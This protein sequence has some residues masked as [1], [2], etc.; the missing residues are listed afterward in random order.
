METIKGYIQY[1]LHDSPGFRICVVR[2]ETPSAELSS[3]KAVGP[4]PVADMDELVEFT[5]EFETNAKY[6]DQFKVVSATP[7]IPTTLAGKK[8]FL[9]NHVDGVGPATADKLLEHFGHDIIDVLDNNPARLKEVVGEKTAEKMIAS[10]Q[11]EHNPYLRQLKLFLAQYGISDGI[12]NRIYDCFGERSIEVIQGNPY[13]LTRVSGIGFKMADNLARALGWPPQCKERVEAAFKYV[14]QESTTAG[15]VF[16]YHGELVDEVR[17]IA[18]INEK[19]TE[20]MLPKEDA[21]EAL[22][23]VVA[24][25]DLSKEP[26]TVNHTPFVLYYL[27]SLYEAEKRVA[28]RLGEFAQLPHY[29]PRGVEETLKRVQKDMHQSLTPLQQQAVISGLSFNVSIITGG[30]GTGKTTTLLSL[31][32]TAKRLKLAVLLAAPTGRA[33]KRMSEVT[34][35]PAQT[36]HRLLEWSPQLADFTRNRDY[37]L[38][39][40]LLL[41]D[42]TSMKDLELMDKLLDA[43]PDHMSVVFIGDVDQLPSVGPGMV[44]R[45]LIKSNRIV[46]T[47]L[48]TIF[49]QAEGS[50]IVQNAHRIRKGENP[51]F[52]GKGVEADSYFIP[53]PQTKND[54]GKSVDSVQYVKEMLPRLVDRVVKK[55]KVDPIRDIQ[56]LT[57]MRKG[58]AGFPEFNIVLQDALNPKGQEMTI[59]GQ[60]F[61]VGDR[62]MQLKNEYDQLNLSNGD[63][64]FI[65]SFDTTSDSKKDHA[66]LIDFYGKTVRYP[67]SLTD[68]LVLAYAQTIH[69]S[70]G[71]EFPAVILVLLNHHYTMLERN[72]LYTAA[73]R[74]KRMCVYLASEEALRTA[75]STNNISKRNTFLSTR[76]RKAIP[77]PIVQPK[78][79]AGQQAAV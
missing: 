58:P 20:K 60:K 46:V 38:E 21:E 70:Q 34:G 64:G 26:V 27:P 30:P 56:V 31:L 42:E 32:H 45:D 3:F 75:V 8:K 77:N 12:S 68:D 62:V 52:P 17:K 33:A 47:R 72:L 35:E 25:G 10:W 78:A 23:N 9:I 57:P 73:T 53:V 36:I 55:L 74:A 39:G 15:N 13:K 59:K 22:A 11:A 28:Q 79:A 50:L 69:K 49:R 29:P 1:T 19:G 65:L 14:L 4:I 16:L 76:I 37:P 6:G 66:I 41:V 2:P 71:S 44:L 51:A 7:V 67:F 61:R 5:G 40:D 24:R 63:I 18:T 48:D 43:V 54:Q